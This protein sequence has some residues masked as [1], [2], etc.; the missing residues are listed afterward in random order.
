MKL[1]AILVVVMLGLTVSNLKSQGIENQKPS[2]MKVFEERLEEQLEIAKANFNE[3]A[4]NFGIN[5]SDETMVIFQMIKRTLLEGVQDED[6]GFGIHLS[7]DDSF[8]ETAGELEKFKNSDFADQFEYHS[9]DGIDT[10]QLDL[11]ENNDRIKE[12]TKSIIETVY[13]KD[14]S[15]IEIDIFPI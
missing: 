4:K 2:K 1:L 15:K 11:K 13:K 10:Y 14:A 7:F 8:V 9:W 3:P 12:I 5:F 6:F